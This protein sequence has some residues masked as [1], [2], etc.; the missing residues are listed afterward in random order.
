MFLRQLK[1]IRNFRQ[2]KDLLNALNLL[3]ANTFTNAN[4]DWAE[5]DNLEEKDV[6]DLDLRNGT[7]DYRRLTYKISQGMDRYA[8]RPGGRAKSSDAFVNAY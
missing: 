5:W 8:S 1:R 6:L 4:P 7:P 3:V 2:I